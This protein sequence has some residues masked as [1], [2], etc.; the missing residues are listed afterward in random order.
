MSS[1]TELIF[2]PLLDLVGLV[3]V[4][5]VFGLV[6][7]DEVPAEDVDVVVVGVDDGEG[8]IPRSGAEGGPCCLGLVL[9]PSSRTLGLVASVG[10]ETFRPSF[11]S[12]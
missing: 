10:P 4:P 9:L 12:G 2:L 5:E 11:C 1:V 7:E 3:A 8:A 6:P